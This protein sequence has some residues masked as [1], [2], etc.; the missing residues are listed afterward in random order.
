[1]FLAG[2]LDGD[3]IEF[4]LGDSGAGGR[5]EEIGDE[6]HLRFV[7]EKIGEGG[8]FRRGRGY[9]IRRK[10]RPLSLRLG[11]IRVPARGVPDGM[12]GRAKM[13]AACR[14]MPACHLMGRP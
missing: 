3:G 9:A 1:M 12:V 14:G 2:G 6:F 8:S 13:G 4:L 11:V 5:E 10:V 7:S